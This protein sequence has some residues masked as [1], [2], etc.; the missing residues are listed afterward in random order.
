MTEAEWLSCNDARPMLKLLRITGRA[1]D[2]KL[3]LFA[4]AC[5]RRAWPVLADERGKKYIE[6]TE[7]LADGLPASESLG[8]A[9]AGIIQ[10]IAPHPGTYY[11][12]AQPDGPPYVGVGSSVTPEA[13]VCMIE[14]MK[15]FNE[16]VADCHG[17]VAEMLVNNQSAVEYGTVLFRV[18]P[19]APLEPREGPESSPS[20]LVREVF[21]NPSIPHRY[22]PPA[23]L[24]WH[25]GVIGKLAQAAYDDRH[26][27]EGTLDTARL[28]ILADALE[29]AGVTEADLLDHLRGPAF[30]VRGCH[31][32]DALLG[33]S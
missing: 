31:V 1:N 17:I 22:V 30:H 9:T 28:A 25:G 26:L 15:I 4:A 7:L 32:L 5:L 20:W 29:E 33:K 23:V 12:Q 13:V 3:R 2:R 14:M 16:I 10:I 18:V 21:G 11:A 6:A 27:P 19:T 24:A 8:A